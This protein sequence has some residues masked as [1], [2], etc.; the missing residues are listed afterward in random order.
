MVK[1]W[2]E[3]EMRNLHRMYMS[4]VPCPTPIFLRS[5]VLMMEFLGSDGWY[6]ENKIS[7][8]FFFFFHVRFSA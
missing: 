1:M 4:R 7:L 2:A 8:A 6:V 3:K 5:H